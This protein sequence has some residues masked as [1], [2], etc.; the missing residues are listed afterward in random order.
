MITLPIEESLWTIEAIAN[1]EGLT[2]MAKCDMIRNMNDDIVRYMRIDILR[3]MNQKNLFDVST[4]SYKE[5]Y[6]SYI[7]IFRS[8]LYGN[9]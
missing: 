7:K 9:S 5:K 3:K 8:Y 1:R 4:T 2:D 6:E